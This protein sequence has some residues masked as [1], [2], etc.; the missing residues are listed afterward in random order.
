M[1]VAIHTNP[2]LKNQI[3]SAAWVAEGFRRQGVTV[4]VTPDKCLKA[5]VQ[6]VQGPWYCLDYW[7]P[8]SD[9]ARVIWLNRCF[10]GDGRFDL[11]LGWL[12]PD[13]SRDF[14]N[15]G[16]AEANGILP[17]LKP[18]KVSN[19]CAIVFA[20]YGRD[21]SE[22]IA[23]ARHEYQ[24]VFF[25]PHPQQ[26]INTRA[27]TLG[28][29]L[30]VCWHWGDV[31]IGHSSTVLVEARINGLRVES[32]DPLHVTHGSDDREGWLT[33]LSWAQWNHEAIKRGAFWE[34]L[35]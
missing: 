35:R 14:R 28:G 8:R 18:D 7:Q 16:K 12:R 30:D 6:V 22:D 3:E 27:I 26:H 25:R 20:D 34:H 17:E 10:Y 23:R 33:R 24:S 19:R 4:N 21:P 11:S 29:P 31:A 9:T 1:Q 15:A 13:G 5:D 2:G 32:S